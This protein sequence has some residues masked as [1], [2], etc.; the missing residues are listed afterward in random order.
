MFIFNNNTIKFLNNN[1]FYRTDC[2]Y[3]DT[4]N[5]K[6]TITC[7]DGID[8]CYMSQG[9]KGGEPFFEADCAPYDST[10]SRNVK[11]CI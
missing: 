11:V 4:M 10:C 9:K 3:C 1:L 2:Y 6:E 7:A 5:C 8:T